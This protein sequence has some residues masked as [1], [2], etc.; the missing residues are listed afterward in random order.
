MTVFTHV[1][2]HYVKDIINHRLFFGEPDEWVRLDRFR[3]L[4]VFSEHQIF[5][6]IRW[7]ANTYGTIDWRLYVLKSG[8]GGQMSAVPGVAPAAKILAFVNGRE[9][10]KRALPVLDRIKAGSSTGF[11]GVPESYWRAVQSHLVLNIPLRQLP[12]HY[13]KNELSHAW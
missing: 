6:Y 2:I 13:R 9:R 1:Q 11:Q 7:R 12:R 10:M 5:G 8:R 3:R 4:A